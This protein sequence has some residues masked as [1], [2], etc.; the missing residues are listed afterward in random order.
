MFMYWSHQIN[1]LKLL[2]KLRNVHTTA[3]TQNMH[4]IDPTFR[5]LKQVI[6][7]WKKRITDF[8]NIRKSWIRPAVIKLISFI[9]LVSEDFDSIH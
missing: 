1:D 4:S 2:I 3:F 7:L 6:Y 9:T 8:E 5:D